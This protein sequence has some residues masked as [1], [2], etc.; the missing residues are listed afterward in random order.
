MGKR[1]FRLKV[2]WKDVR[3]IMPCGPSDATIQTLMKT[4]EDR[5]RRHCGLFEHQ[6]KIVQ[7]RTEDDF[8]INPDDTIEGTLSE[9]TIVKVI[10]RSD[11][12]ELSSQLG[13]TFFSIISKKKKVNNELIL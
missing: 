6:F 3:L 7:L 12:I 1:F 9:G 11:W 4:I 8:I 10:E 2:L 5:I 13:I